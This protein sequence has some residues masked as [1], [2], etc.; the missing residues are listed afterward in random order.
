MDSGLFIRSNESF[1]FP[2]GFKY[3]TV[4]PIAMEAAS[5]KVKI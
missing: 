4:L 3:G 5:I 2:H 1:S